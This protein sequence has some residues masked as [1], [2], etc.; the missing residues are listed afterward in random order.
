MEQDVEREKWL[1]QAAAE[2]A[3][4]AEPEPEP[5]PEP[6]PVPASKMEIDPFD[7]E[8]AGQRPPHG[9]N[10]LVESFGIK[11]SGSAE[12]C[13]VK[14]VG[15]YADRWAVVRADSM[16]QCDQL[17]RK[18]LKLP[19]GY[20]V[21]LTPA[22][23]SAPYAWPLALLDCAQSSEPLNGV[24]LKSPSLFTLMILAGELEDMDLSVI[25]NRNAK[26][27]CVET[28]RGEAMIFC[29]LADNR[30]QA[31]QLICEL[32]NALY[33]TGWERPSFYADPIEAII[34]ERMQQWPLDE[35]WAM[36]W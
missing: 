32:C 10:A 30:Y 34:D 17:V 24:E 29:A 33:R 12:L 27:D 19:D 35:A 16:E 22:Y 6:V 2:L 15:G 13:E 14:I 4:P 20:G 36:D 5:E 11:H 31:Q 25:A 18:A 28:D 3:P 1:V 23:T 21:S 7:N 8:A 26:Y 9:A